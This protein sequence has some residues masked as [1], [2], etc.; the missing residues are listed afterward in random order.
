MYP[1]LLGLRAAWWVSCIYCQ[2]T[3]VSNSGATTITYY[4]LFVDI[5]L[6]ARHKARRNDCILL[7]AFLY[8]GLQF[9]YYWTWPICD[10]DGYKILSSEVW[11]WPGQPE[12]LW[13]MY[14]GRKWSRE[15]RVR[16]CLCLRILLS[17]PQPGAGAQHGPL[18]TEELRPDLAQQL[19]Q[20]QGEWL[21]RK[22]HQ[23]S[24]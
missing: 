21:Q 12:L 11:W 1:G 16:P 19:H 9:T 5:L 22:R 6:A 3:V 23:E 4:Y 2:W 13:H 7:L 18:Q 15:S 17:V 14:W 24:R 10:N 8:R 20:L